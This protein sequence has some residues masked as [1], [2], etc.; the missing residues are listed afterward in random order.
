MRISDWSS[1][2]CSSDLPGQRTCVPGPAVLFSRGGVEEVASD[3]RKRQYL[4]GVRLSEEERTALE[5]LAA[6]RQTSLP[7]FLRAAG[8]RPRLASSAAPITFAAR[9]ELRRTKMDLGAVGS[10]LHPL[11]NPFAS[12]QPPT[13]QL[14]P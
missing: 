1:D 3:K 8:L 4:I 6:S 5:A 9:D 11:P 7:A 14:A 2:V 13:S 12:T 10:R